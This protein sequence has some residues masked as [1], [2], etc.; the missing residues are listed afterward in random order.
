MASKK[1][2]AVVG[3]TG[4][5]GGGLVNAILSHADGPFTARAVTR[6][7]DSDAAKAL[8]GRGAEVAQAD[9]DDVDSLTRAFSGCHGIFAITNF[10]E[11]FSAEKEKDQA[12][13][14]AQAAKSADVKHVIWSTLEDTRKRL[15]ISD[16]RMPV[17]QEKYNV[18]HFDAKGEADQ[19]FRDAGVPTSFLLTAFYW[20]N[21]ITFGAGPQRG[22]DGVLRLTMCIGDK[23]LPGI[24]VAD[25]GKV[26]YAIYEGGDAHFG[27]TIGIA[28]GHP[29]GAEM[30][31]A[32]TKAFGEEVVYTD[33]PPDVF[34]SF[35]FDGADEMGNMYQYKRD[36]NESFVDAR[37]LDVAHK[38]NPEMLTFEAWLEQNADRIPR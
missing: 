20:E 34:R 12:Y 27:Q 26:A 8:A 4:A 16:S 5:Q 6:R 19:Y 2:I 30:A 18:P 28:G 35:P 31:A 3:A 33:V 25:I 1:T 11:H 23:K 15:A 37:A 29:T 38:L 21:F 17:L 10:W 9:L 36:F 13:N 24:A 22:E 14:L 7:P 32:M